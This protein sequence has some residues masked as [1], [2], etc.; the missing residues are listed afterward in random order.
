MRSVAKPAIKKIET[1]LSVRSIYLIT[2]TILEELDLTVYHT[3]SE[4]GGGE[5]SRKK[6][7]TN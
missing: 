6:R 5:G 1:L 7:N 4:L 2:S 3:Y